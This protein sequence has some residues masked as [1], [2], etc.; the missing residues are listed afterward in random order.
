MTDD[1][2]I[3]KFATFTHPDKDAAL[4]HVAFSGTQIYATDGRVAVDGR[5]SVA[6][7]E[8]IPEKYPIKSLEEILRAPRATQ[9]WFT[10]NV[11]EFEGL[12]QQFKEAYEAEWNEHI[13]SYRTRYIEETCPCCD[14]TVYW[15][16]WKEEL[17][18]EKEETPSF[19]LREVDKSTWI[20]F[21]NNESVLVNFCYLHMLVHAFG[22]DLR[23]AVGH[24]TDEKNPMLHLKT[25]DERF[26]GV[27]MPL[28]SY[29][30]DYMAD[31]IL[32]AEAI[33]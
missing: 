25:V 10:I 6:R 16:S 26:Y 5:L 13:R 4:A 30:G 12:E 22:R 17:V 24:C 8:A 32:H 23:L 9:N 28:R 19:D 27:L 15:D 7:P 11:V 14:K 20:R 29:D 2:I 3:K 18:K 21:A 31:F 33:G 1:E